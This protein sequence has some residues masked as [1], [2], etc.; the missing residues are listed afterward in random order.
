MIGAAGPAKMVGCNTAFGCDRRG[1][2]TAPD[3]ALLHEAGSSA[4]LST[5]EGAGSDTAEIRAM[6]FRA[7]LTCDRCAELDAER[8]PSAFRWAPVGC[9]G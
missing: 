4:P 5:A 7:E 6:H 8:L 2:R 1:R 9:T 3:C